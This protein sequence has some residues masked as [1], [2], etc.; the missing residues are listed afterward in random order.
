MVES[1]VALR[2]GEE[3]EISVSRELATARVALS[4]EATVT[5]VQ[6]TEG[7]ARAAQGGAGKALDVPSAAESV[8]AAQDAAVSER[9]PLLVARAIA[10]DD[11]DVRHQSGDGSKNHGQGAQ[12]QRDDVPRSVVKG[13]PV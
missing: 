1:A 12:G 9:V 3:I 4:E 2:G 5:V 7:K 8:S 11:S 10:H 13:P 6:N